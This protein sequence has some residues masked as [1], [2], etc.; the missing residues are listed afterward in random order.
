MNL[1]PEFFSQY[2]YFLIVDLEATCCDQRSFP[3]NE[4][5]IIEIGAVLVERKGLSVVDEFQTFIQPVRNPQ[6]T[7]FCHQLT[8]IRQADVD[9]APRFPDALQAMQSWLASYENYLFCSWG[10][11]D[12]SQFI[13]D[14]RYHRVPFPFSDAHLNLK[15]QF[16]ITQGLK[17]RFGMAG[18]LQKAGI[19]LQGTHHRGID[20]ARNMAQLMPW[21]IGGGT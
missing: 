4:M 3:R 16:S 20:D 11:Y 1:I 12:K 18:A 19:P 17:K 2:Q 7:S 13:Q 10:D 5:E 9:Q 8:S 14:C 21:I 6:L 15:K